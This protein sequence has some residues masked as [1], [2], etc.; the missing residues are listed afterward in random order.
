M[1]FTTRKQRT[2]LSFTAQRASTVCVYNRQAALSRHARL[3]HST[4]PV[5]S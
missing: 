1:F 5:A 4:K 2:S 3:H